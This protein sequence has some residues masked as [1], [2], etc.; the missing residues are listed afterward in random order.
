MKNMKNATRAL[1][2]AITARDAVRDILS[3]NS[4]EINNAVMMAAILHHAV[5]EIA[6]LENKDANEE[7]EPDD[8]ICEKTLAFTSKKALMILSKTIARSK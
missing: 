4:N 1:A 8:E 7:T 6:K 3:E 2:I 5:T